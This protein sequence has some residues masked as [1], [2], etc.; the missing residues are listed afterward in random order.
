MTKSLFKR[1]ENII[2]IM[3]ILAFI[4]ILQ[5]F[6]F[7]KSVFEYDIF[8]NGI[9]IPLINNGKLAIEKFFKIPILDLEREIWISLIP[10]FLVLLI[11]NVI[12]THLFFVLLGTITSFLMFLLS[13]N[14]LNKFIDFKLKSKKNHYLEII[15]SL[16]FTVL[17]NLSFGYILMF[18]TISINLILFLITL[19]GKT[20]LFVSIYK[21]KQKLDNDEIKEQINKKYPIVL[22]VYLFTS[23]FAYN[24]ILFILDFI[25][26]ALF[27]IAVYY[28]IGIKNIILLTT[29]FSIIPNLITLFI[30]I[31]IFNPLSYSFL[32]K[33]N[34]T[35]QNLID[36]LYYQGFWSSYS[37]YDSQTQ[38]NIEIYKN[39]LLSVSS[40]TS[41]SANSIVLILCTVGYY[42]WYKSIQNKTS[43]KLFYFI[44]SILVIYIIETFIF[45]GFRSDK[46][47][48]NS[49]ILFEIFK[50]FGVVMFI[51]FLFSLLTRKYK[52]N[53]L[54]MFIFI[55][56]I[57]QILIISPILFNDLRDN[58]FAFKIQE[59]FKTNVNSLNDIHNKTKYKNYIILP[60]DFNKYE[61]GFG[62][63]SKI[64]ILTLITSFEFMWTKQ[65]Y[66]L[67]LINIIKNNTPL[68]SQYLQ[69]KNINGIIFL[70]NLIL[71]DDLDMLYKNLQTN[72]TNYLLLLDENP[73]FLVYGK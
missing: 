31:F 29:K 40:V 73:T 11:N 54:G 16:V 55:V 41:L 15:L 18:Y 59:R 34:T 46:F 20:Y 7:N 72:L 30:S 28:N 69:I 67:E 52:I 56:I 50:F 60:F 8:S 61:Q 35:A 39:L 58:Y 19:L 48:P 4:I 43:I 53:L 66:D 6:L 51:G 71:N 62:R 10:Y 1:K 13:K 3:F 57:F 9:D 70:K 49:I 64:H 33:S 26:T 21:V 27:L 5:F 38:L 12:G 42:F 63:L 65:I 25:L 47:L 36:I 68:F 17:I 45:F 37:V 22:L 2:I 24:Q 44:L 32:F 23:G 14:L